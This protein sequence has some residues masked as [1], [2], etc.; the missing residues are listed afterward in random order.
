MWCR[1]GEDTRCW[2]MNENRNLPAF[3]R[4]IK[5][6]YTLWQV[7][8]FLFSESCFNSRWGH[9]FLSGAETYKFLFPSNAFSKWNYPLFLVRSTSNLFLMREAHLSY[10]FMYNP[11]FYFAIYTSE[12]E[13]LIFQ[14]ADSI[15]SEKTEETGETA[16]FVFHFLN[17]LNLTELL[18]TISWIMS[19]NPLID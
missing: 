9:N 14:P 6:T 13:V 2:T 4:E 16:Q 18:G 10:C 5:F 3:F 11:S 1:Q 7:Y 19:N 15:S 12:C 17:S 8:F